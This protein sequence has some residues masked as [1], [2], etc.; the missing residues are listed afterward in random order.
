MGLEMLEPSL[1]HVILDCLLFWLGFFGWDWLHGSSVTIGLLLMSCGEPC[2]ACL[3]KHHDLVAVRA[4]ARNIITNL[5]LFVG[6]SLFI[7]MIRTLR[8]LLVHSALDA[9]PAATARTLSSSV[10]FC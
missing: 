6:N 10:L 7:L 2:S 9:S 4:W 5:L 8:L 1:M 3:K